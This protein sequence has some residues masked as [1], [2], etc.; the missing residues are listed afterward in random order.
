MANIKLNTLQIGKLGE[1]EVQKRFL[2]LGYD[3]S[4]LTT[5]SGIDL[6]VLLKSKYLTLQV[7]TML[8]AAKAGGKGPLAI[9]WYAPVNNQANYFAFV[10]Y[11]KKKIWL[12][13]I[14][15]LEKLFKNGQCQKKNGKYHLSMYIEKNI[16]AK[17]I[18]DKK[19]YS[20]FLL[21]SRIKDLENKI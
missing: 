11:E 4:H 21:E 12:F 6:V 14:K 10:Y 18:K 9:D 7:K 2:E 20:K 16:N 1:L 3:S 15:E 8:V 17:K 5:D 13:T 19:Y